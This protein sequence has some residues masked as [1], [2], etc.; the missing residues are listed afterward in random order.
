MIF[1]HGTKGD[2]D[3][4]LEKGLLSARLLGLS[5]SETNHSLPY[6]HETMNRVYFTDKIEIAFTYARGEG[7]ILTLDIPLEV[8]CYEIEYW[9][10]D[11]IPPGCIIK[12][13]KS[14]VVAER[15]SKLTLAQIDEEFY[16]GCWA[17]MGNN[18]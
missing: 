13:E 17:R 18:G 8:K 10:M 14:S 15:E 5:W 7:H 4:I 3:S 1:Y 2:I 9:V 11:R 6:F 12:V 16:E